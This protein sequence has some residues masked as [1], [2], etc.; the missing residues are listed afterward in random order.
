M[1]LIVSPESWSRISDY[2]RRKRENFVELGRVIEGNREV[3][4]NSA[5]RARKSAATR[6]A[7]NG[8]RTAS[9]D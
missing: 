6:P 5:P 3:I 9:N 4:F 1:V 7:R 2:L 8:R